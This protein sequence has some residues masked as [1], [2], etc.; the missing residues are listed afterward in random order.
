MIPQMLHAQGLRTWLVVI[1]LA[2]AI[3]LGGGGSPAPLPELLL[4]VIAAICAAI[5]LIFMPT[6]QK[7]ASRS[8]WPS[9]YSAWLIPA[10]LVAVPALQ[11]IPLPPA[12]WHA[13]PGRGPEQAALDLIGEANSWR[14]WSVLPERT[15]ASLLAMAVPTALI[16][17]VVRLDE[18]GRRQLLA[19]IVV[20]G[21]VMTLL[22][23]TLQLS[24]QSFLSYGAQDTQLLGFQANHNS[25]ADILLVAMI[26]TAA[27]TVQRLRREATDRRITAWWGLCIG[28]TLLL[29]LGIFLTASRAGI[30]LIP[31]ALLAQLA[32]A[33]PRRLP[34]I[35]VLAFG[36]LIALAGVIVTAVVLRDNPVIGRVIARFSFSGE[37]RP[38]IWIDAWFAMRQYWPFGSGMGTFVP[39]F[40]PAERLDVLDEFIANRAHNDFL[41][42][43][44]EAGLV[45]L[46]VL[47]AVIFFVANAARRGLQGAGRSD[48][49]IIVFSV[50]ALFIL[51]LH[52]LVDY[53]LRSMSLA[54]VAA[55]AAGLI[56]APRGRSP[57]RTTSLKDLA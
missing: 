32:I 29:I 47:C 56:L 53:P 37:F 3:I 5:W 20:V 27:W 48:R 40:M 54:C 45:G 13:L 2:S 50:A 8:D 12:V 19:V 9:A 15:L 14:S 18:S 36:T 33:N 23:G 4:Q 42:L 1:L 25:T 10:L 31:V 26:A 30:A 49:A 11:L 24:G 16:A 21:G 39:V 55:T 22:L 34:S 7:A 38:S 41:E 35:R 6:K 28:L 43:A 46:G 17:M 51:G 57:N 52:S 44:I